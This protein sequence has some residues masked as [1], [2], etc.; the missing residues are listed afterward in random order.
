MYFLQELK[1]YDASFKDFEIAAQPINGYRTG[2]FN[3]PETKPKK[4]GYI[5][6]L[7]ILLLRARDPGRSKNPE[8]E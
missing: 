6:A 4:M 3:S 2:Q 1:W 7:Q 8:E 5:P